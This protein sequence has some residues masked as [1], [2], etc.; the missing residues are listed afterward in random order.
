[1]AVASSACFALWTTLLNNFAVERAA[2]SGADMGILQSVREIPGF[3]AFTAIYLLLLMTEQRLAMIS[4]LCLAL[5][6][7]AT[8]L[9]PSF[10]GLLITTTVM[11]I[12]FHYFETVS[13]SLALQWL[14]IAR[15]PFVLGRLLAARSAAS[16]FMMGMV[17]LAFEWFGLSY[18]LVY[19]LGGGSVALLVLLIWIGFPKFP[20]L[21]PQRKH[22]FLRTRY[23]LFYALIFFS[24]ARRQIFVVFAGFLLVERFGYSVADIT[25]L[26]I[27]NALL[28]IWIAPWIGRLISRIGERRVLVIEYVG[29]V[30]VFAGYGLAEVGW[31]AALLY[32][33]DH[34]FF[35]MAIGIRTYFQKIGDPADMASSAAVSFTINHI[36]AVFIPALFGLIWMVDPS[37]VFFAGAAMAA[38]SLLLAS[39]VPRHPGPGHETVLSQP[40]SVAALQ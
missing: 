8:G 16:I 31:L 13:Q 14:P 37:A 19:L 32:V 20:E 21:V 30:I 17:W 22:L 5:G 23:W 12:G 11:S 3:L 35:A 39:L 9:L 33:V 38:V 29:L 18:L 24:G 25:L 26:Y 15:A 36:A 40:Q 6:T 4:L 34:L 10:S 1:M 2:F 28:N 27:V 7:A